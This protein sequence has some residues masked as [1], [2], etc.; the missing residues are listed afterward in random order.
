[1]DK[2]INSYQIQE[3]L[4]NINQKKFDNA[5][6]K[7]EKLSIK[8]PNNKILNKLFASTY[9]NKRD[10]HNSIKYHEI[11]LSDEKDKYK[12]FTNI[13]YAYFKLGKIHQSIDAYQN[14]IKEN[15]NFELAY[16]NLAISYI[17]I[18]QYEKAYSVFSKILKLNSNNYFAQKNLIYLLNFINPKKNEEDNFFLEINN[19]IKNFTS[20]FNLNDLYEINNLKKIFLNSDKEIEKYYKNLSFEETQIYR[21]NSTDLNCKRHFQV[22]NKFNVIPKFCFSCYKVQINLKNVIDLIKLYF[23][24]DFISL[25]NNNIRKCL[26]ELRKNV[27]GNYK[28]YIYCRE[29]NEA[30]K[31]QKEVNNLIKQEFKNY[32][33]EIKHG[34]TEFYKSFPKFNNINMNG[35]QDIEYDEEWTKKEN[36]IDSLE[37]LRSELDQK[38]LIESVK[39]INLSDILIIKNWLVYA[40]IIGDESYKKIYTDKPQNKFLSDILRDQLSFRKSNQNHKLLDF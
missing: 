2:L 40:S 24:F 5:I 18:G 9:F 34:C 37:P 36:I 25:E 23:V 13:G 1:M 33:I 30:K 20:N 21:K 11:I 3:I 35:K 12:I 10:W 8:F 14:S 26:V 19:K 6:S 31:I 22:F 4:D 17:E 39:G 7:I 38:V 15:S 28:G 16:N 32:K 29:L 27:N